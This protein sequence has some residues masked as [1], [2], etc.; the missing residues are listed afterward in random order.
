MSSLWMALVAQVPCVVCEQLGQKTASQVHHLR[1]NDMGKRKSDRLVAA[2][3]LEHHT[4]K[5][6]IHTDRERFER[7]FGSE[8][9]LLDLTLAGVEKILKQHGIR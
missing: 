7:Q 8:I 2:L 4:G 5:Y 1:F 3:C 9:D 6:S